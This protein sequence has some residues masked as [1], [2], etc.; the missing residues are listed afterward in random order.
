MHTKDNSE[1]GLE[2][3]MWIKAID[4]IIKNKAQ[5]SPLKSFEGNYPNFNEDQIKIKNQVG[6]FLK[7]W[8][9]LSNF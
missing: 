3:N 9:E 7:V 8:D 5:L 4:E 1:T 2:L 6:N